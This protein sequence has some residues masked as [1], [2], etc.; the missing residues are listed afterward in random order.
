MAVRPK[1]LGVPVVGFDDALDDPDALERG[2]QGADG[3]S[4]KT[5]EPRD[6][7]ETQRAASVDRQ[8]TEAGW[9]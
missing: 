8:G 4:C 9:A 5:L 2:D 1:E 6:D 3:R 7:P